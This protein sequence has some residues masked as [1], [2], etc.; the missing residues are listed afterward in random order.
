[1][2]ATADRPVIIAGSGVHTSMAWPQLARLAEH[3]GLPV[4]TTIHGKGSLP[5]SHPL[6]L[7][8]VGN[9][10]AR[11]YANDYVRSA[12]AVLFIGTR[13]NATDT[14]AWTGPPRSGVAVAQIDIDPGRAGRNFTDAIPL[15]G[16]A[17][18]VMDQL[19]AAL[20][21]VDPARLAARVGDLAA[22][23]NVWSASWP[24]APTA[25]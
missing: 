15:A 17:A 14:N 2:L 22:R 24:T 9:N 3:A 7:G 6:A 21:A 1:M 8:V 13:A 19:R 4:A 20:P 18:T 12:D 11:D 25:P 23:R 16:D 10:G 5:D